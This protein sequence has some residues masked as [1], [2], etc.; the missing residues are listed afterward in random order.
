MYIQ[1]VYGNFSREISK[2]TVIIRCILTF[3]AN[4]TYACLDI[5]ILTFRT[6]LAATMCMWATLAPGVTFHKCMP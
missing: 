4:P 5:M 6:K 1:F 2:Y 3:L